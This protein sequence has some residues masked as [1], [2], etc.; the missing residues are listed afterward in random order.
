MLFP[1]V[2][3]LFLKETHGK[4]RKKHHSW[5]PPPMPPSPQEIFGFIKGLLT[6][7][8]PLN[9]ALVQRQKIANCP[10]FPWNKQRIKGHSLTF[11]NCLLISP[12]RM[13]RRTLR[14]K[15]DSGTG[16]RWRWCRLLRHEKP[17]KEPTSDVSWVGSYPPSHHQGEPRKKP[18]YF[19]LHWMVN[20]D[21]YNGLWNNPYIPG[22]CN[23]L[24]NPTNQVFFIAQ[25]TLHSL[26]LTVPEN[27]WLEDEMSF[28]II[29]CLTGQINC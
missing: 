20:R 27:Q 4:K 7:I 29:P 25:V 21:P 28:L 26:K 14:S 24:Y 15:W 22:S 5:T 3:P 11:C 2:A 17:T 12:C 1:V 23:P 10:P 6:T 19:P 18:S 13:L 16:R 9:I 8:I